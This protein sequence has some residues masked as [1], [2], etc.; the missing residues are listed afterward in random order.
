MNQDLMHTL[1]QITGEEQEIL[2]GRTQVR[3]TLYTAGSDFTID[4]RKMLEKGR[5]IDVRT[6]T[7]FIDFPRH[8]HNYIEI[9]Y[10]CRGPYNT[11]HQQWRPGYAGDRRSAVYEPAL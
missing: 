5:L 4:S 9:M 3:K 2:D 8:K 1:E 11:Y 6:H 10:M 7:R